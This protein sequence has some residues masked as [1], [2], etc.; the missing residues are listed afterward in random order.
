[1]EKLK[2]SGLKR[3]YIFRIELGPYVGTER[4]RYATWWAELPG[5]RI[6]FALQRDKTILARKIVEGA[7]YIDPM[8][9]HKWATIFTG[10]ALYHEIRRELELVSRPMVKTCSAE[11]PKT[12]PYHWH[13]FEVG[14]GTETLAKWREEV[15]YVLEHKYNV[16]DWSRELP[17]IEASHQP[18][19]EAAHRT[20]NGTAG[21]GRCIHSIR[22]F[23]NWLRS[24]NST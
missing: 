22:S 18:E 11:K 13:T 2:L 3:S 9:L 1:M 12:D 19:I 8:D 23:A 14:F 5:S 17:E 4:R 16:R 6:V 10:N 20:I 7:D 15:L 24:A 21:G